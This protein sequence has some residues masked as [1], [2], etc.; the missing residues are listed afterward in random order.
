MFGLALALLSQNVE[1]STSI[2]DSGCVSCC[3]GYSGCPVAT[4]CVTLPPPVIVS[5]KDYLCD[6]VLVKKYR[7]RL[8]KCCEDGFDVLD[9]SFW[10]VVIC[11]GSE[12]GLKISIEG[13]VAA[14]LA[15]IREIEKKDCIVETPTFKS[16]TK[17]IYNACK[18][19]SGSDIDLL[20]F[21]AIAMHN[22]YSFVKFTTADRNDCSIGAKSRGLLQIKSRSYYEDI[23]SFGTDYISKPWALD[24]FTEKSIEDEFSLF[25]RS[26]GRAPDGG[27]RSM[28]SSVVAMGSV[29]S[30]LLFGESVKDEAL[31]RKRL[32]RRSQIFGRLY[33]NML[34][35]QSITKA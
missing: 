14:V 7:S 19:Q 27:K 30:A 16:V 8:F 13:Y 32:S 24:Y 20:N 23:S 22:M 33:F 15:T 1:A 2:F 10:P 34:L 9:S 12:P 28:S 35:A 31:A 26:F 18:A 3:T 17:N 4:A 21:T 6:G 29:E 5:C 11:F 25:L